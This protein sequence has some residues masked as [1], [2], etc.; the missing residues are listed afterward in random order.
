MADS[1]KIK[2]SE[3]V[4][5]TSYSGAYVPGVDSNGDTKKFPLSPLLADIAN[6]VDKVSGKGLSTNDYTDEDKA[7]LSSVGTGEYVV[8]DTLPT[9][10]A[11][12]MNKIYLIPSGTGDARIMY[13][14]VKDGN[15]Y[16]WQSIDT[17]DIDVSGMV[18]LGTVVESNV[19]MTS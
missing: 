17:T 19:V 11:S 14:T 2:I 13:V 10:S 4:G 5:S 9:A 16:S 6:K 3:L 1:E 18:V 15:T 8:A 7:K 12:T